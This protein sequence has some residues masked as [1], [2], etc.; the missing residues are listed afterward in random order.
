[1]LASP[2]HHHIGRLR[3]TLHL[4]G[5]LM[6]EPLLQL[7]SMG[8][9]VGDAGEL[10]EAGGSELGSSWSAVAGSAAGAV[11]AGGTGT[12]VTKALTI[13]GLPVAAVG[14]VGD[15]LHLC[16]AVPQPFTRGERGG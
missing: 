1:M 12:A 5:D 15:E 9:L 8:E 16:C 4:V 7:K 2:H 14:L 6:G 13:E 11:G 3:D 10:G